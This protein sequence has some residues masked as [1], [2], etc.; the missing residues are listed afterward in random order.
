MPTIDGRLVAV[1][2]EL[3]K[4]AL[5]NELE[6]AGQTNLPE[7]ARAADSKR[8]EG[9]KQV[10]ERRMQRASRGHKQCQPHLSMGGMVFC[11]AGSSISA[12]IVVQ[13]RWLRTA[14]KTNTR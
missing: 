3:D 11:S 10:S 14:N 5:G 4:N 2:R 13:M 9:A 12:Q 8:R 1:A 7:S 6:T